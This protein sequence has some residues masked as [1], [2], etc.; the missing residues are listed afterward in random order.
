MY[1]GTSTAAADF[2][3]VDNWEKTIGGGD[4]SKYL[5]KE[6]F[7]AFKATYNQTIDGLEHRITDLETVI[8]RSSYVITLQKDPSTAGSVS[9]G[10]RFVAGTEVTVV[11]T[12]DAEG[13]YTAFDGW[14]EGETKVSENASYTFTV[15]GARTLVAKFK[16]G[17]NIIPYTANAKLPN[18]DQ[19]AFGD[20]VITSHTF[21]GSAGKI[22][23]NVNVT[24]IGGDAFYGCSGL[25][26]ITIPD[27]VTS[28]GDYAFYGCSGLTSITIPD[29]VTSIGESAFEDCTGLTSVTCEA[30]TPPTLGSNAFNNNA[31]GRKIY[32]P[33]ASVNAYKNANNWSTYAS[34]IEAISA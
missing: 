24:S 6:A 31:S 16:Y 19:G 32:V 4:P 33:S 11:A 10:G 23:F 22:K 5:T 20:A 9:G 28:I 15:S 17:N 34:D 2:S 3:N 26:S 27:S 18:F 29:S 1:L 13:D 7:E 25:T 8:N 30:T 14:Y 12:P 21:D